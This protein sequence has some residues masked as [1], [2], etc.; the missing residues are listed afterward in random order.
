MP[1]QAESPQQARQAGNAE[2][3]HGLARKRGHGE[4]V[5]ANALGLSPAGVGARERDEQVTG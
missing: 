4:R 1:K 2:K 3:W 5:T